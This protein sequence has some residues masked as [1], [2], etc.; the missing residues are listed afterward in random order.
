[1][2]NAHVESL[3]LLA[4]LFR[5][6]TPQPFVLSLVVQYMDLCH[7]RHPGV[8]PH[9]AASLSH[10]PPLRETCSLNIDTSMV[11]NKERERQG[12]G[13]TPAMR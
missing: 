5:E 7:H 10:T 6:G 12:L 8:R 9:Y 4:T 3:Q 1:M 13:A 11:A 2:G